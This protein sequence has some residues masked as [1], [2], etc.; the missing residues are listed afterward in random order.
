M[1]LTIRP[2]SAADLAAT[3]E[4]LEKAGL[5]VAD[6]SAERLAFVAEKD[7]LFQG[8][9]G[10]ESFGSVALLRS[11][12]V[13]PDARGAGIGA[14]LVTALEIVSLAD[15]VS[16]LWLLTIDADRFFAKLGYVIRDRADAPET[17]RNTEELSG[18]CPGDA[19]LMS[20]ELS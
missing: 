2:A 15:G 6:L 11:L 4:L 17:I 1:T 12:V 13:S 5:P 20:K 10:Q 16:E 8:V 14:A 9:I 7:D 18:L 19:V 3:I